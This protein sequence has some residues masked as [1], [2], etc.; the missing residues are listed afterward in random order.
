MTENDRPR[1]SASSPQSE[2]CGLEHSDTLQKLLK[3]IGPVALNPSDPNAV[4]RQL[5]WRVEWLCW[6]WQTPAGHYPQEVTSTAAQALIQQAAIE[7]LR[8]DERAVSIQS[9]AKCLWAVMVLGPAIVSVNGGPYAK[10]AREV[11]IEA[12]GPTLLDAL[13][14]A[15]EAVVKEKG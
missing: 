11:I 15:V 10:T 5:G 6:V 3:L 12:S 14:K 13:L 9:P 2:V 4:Y 1:A 7:W 8:Q